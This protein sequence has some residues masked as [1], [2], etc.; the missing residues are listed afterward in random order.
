M[1]QKILNKTYIALPCNNGFKGNGKFTWDYNP[2]RRG[3]VCSGC[4]KE[5]VKFEVIAA[6]L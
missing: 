2:I 3:F 1:E 5:L 4:K 6:N